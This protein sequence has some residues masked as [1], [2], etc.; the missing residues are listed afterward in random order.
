MV[1]VPT[2]IAE[3]GECC[4]WPSLQP[5]LLPH[6]PHPTLGR[7]P[8]ACGCMQAVPPAAHCPHPY[9]LS[10]P[11]HTPTLIHTWRCV[12]WPWYMRLYAGRSSGCSSSAREVETANGAAAAAAAAAVEV[13]AVAVAAAAACGIMRTPLMRCPSCGGFS[14]SRPTSLRGGGGPDRGNVACAQSAL[15]GCCGA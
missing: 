8:G 9:T 2:H 11:P 12:T 3:G 5:H 7:G 4:R 10:T 13:G 14:A 6:T 1:R 15:T